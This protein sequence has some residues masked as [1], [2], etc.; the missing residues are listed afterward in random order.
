MN[1]PVLKTGMAFGSSWVRIPS[2]PLLRRQNGDSGHNE[3]RPESSGRCLVLADR[4][5]YAPLRPAINYSIETFQIVRPYFEG[6]SRVAS[7]RGFHFL[8]VGVLPL[9][10]TTGRALAKHVMHRAAGPRLK[11]SQCVGRHRDSSFSGR[12][13]GARAGLTNRNAASTA[14]TLIVLRTVQG[15]V[16]RSNAPP[17]RAPFSPIDHGQAKGHNRALSYSSFARCRNASTD[18]RY[19]AANLSMSVFLAR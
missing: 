12:G 4:V 7:G 6:T 8:D 15:P 10:H 18:S 16:C 13:I 14:S 1:A 17:G 9:E 19:A 11:L 2:P 3:Q 5:R